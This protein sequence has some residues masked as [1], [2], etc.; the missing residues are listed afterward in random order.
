MDDARLNE[1]LEGY[2][3]DALTVGMQ[4]NSSTQRRS[5]AIGFVPNR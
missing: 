1:A 2:H 3:I 5:G 4:L